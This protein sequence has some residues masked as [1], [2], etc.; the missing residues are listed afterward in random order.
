MSSSTMRT[1]AA[2]KSRPRDDPT[3]I[4]N[5]LGDPR[6]GNNAPED[7]HH[8]SRRNLGPGVLR[9]AQVMKR[10]TS[11]AGRHRHWAQQDDE[12]PTVRRG[13]QEIAD[14]RVVLLV[15]GGPVPM[16]DRIILRE[17]PVSGTGWQSCRPR[18]TAVTPSRIASTVPVGGRGR[19]RQ[20]GQLRLTRL[21][22]AWMPA[23]AAPRSFRGLTGLCRT[24]A[25]PLSSQVCLPSRPPEMTWTGISLVLGSCLQEIE[26]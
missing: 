1:F 3:S 25:A 18:E 8:V 13:S 12:A 15:R 14:E 7:R 24:L 19:D 5:G 11:R 10:S 26:Q 4:V 2:F 21:R 6:P 16:N 9:R 17:A 20:P 23:K 22:V